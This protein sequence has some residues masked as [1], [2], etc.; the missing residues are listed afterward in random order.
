[1]YVCRHCCKGYDAGACGVTYAVWSAQTASAC[2]RGGEF[3]ATRWLHDCVCVFGGLWVVVVVGGADLNDQGNW[4]M[5]E[6]E[7]KLETFSAIEFWPIG[8]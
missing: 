4:W 6:G 5:C 1:M 2:E 7:E 3:R 8:F